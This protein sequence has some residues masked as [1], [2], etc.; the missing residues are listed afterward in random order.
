MR[1]NFPADFRQYEKILLII[2]ITR[3]KEKN[4]DLKSIMTK[5]FFVGLCLGVL[6]F[7][8][9]LSSPASAVVITDIV[10]GTS[11]DSINYFVVGQTFKADQNN[12]AGVYVSTGN[13]WE[14]G[15]N[16]VFFYLCKGAPDLTDVDGTKD[17]TGAGNEF[18]YSTSTVQTSPPG[19]YSWDHTFSFDPIE[20]L[21]LSDY[22]FVVSVSFSNKAWSGVDSSAYSGGYRFYSGG[23]S[24]GDMYFTTYYDDGYIPIPDEKTFYFQPN[25]SGEINSSVKIPFT[26]LPQVYTSSTDQVGIY[27]CAGENYSV[28]DCNNLTFMSSS[29]V[30]SVWDV[31]NDDPFSVS[32]NSFVSITAPTYSVY[33]TYVALAHSHLFNH[34]FGPEYFSVNF[35]STTFDGLPFSDGGDN[36]QYWCDNPCYDLATSTLLGWLTCAPR[37]AFCWAFQSSASSSGYF[38]N[39]FFKLKLSFPFNAYFDIT[40]A[41]T[42]LATTTTETQ[43]F[44]IPVPSVGTDGKATITMETLITASTTKKVIGESNY[45]NIRQGIVWFLWIVFAG[46]VIKRL[47]HKHI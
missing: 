34:T 47:S 25:N 8:F 45:T 44:K 17:C 32:G 24:G 21:P 15:P 5:K 2:M 22:Y 33:R 1:W 37:E 10:Q 3:N 27:Q 20:L 31:L 29:S 46:Y 16:T 13:Q 28:P 38:S 23:G 14:E 30:W 41:L 26:F 12:I 42:G 7:S 11:N 39:A 40:D 35:G 43:G 19:Y 6:F 36:Y 18:L 9:F 4:K